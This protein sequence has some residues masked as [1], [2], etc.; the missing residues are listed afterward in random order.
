MKKLRTYLNLP[1]TPS[2]SSSSPKSKPSI[3]DPMTYGPG[4]ATITTVTGPEWFS[5][6][7]LVAGH[8]NPAN[9]V[10]PVGLGQRLLR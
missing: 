2:S 7:K 10:P 9:E 6:K 4:K 8:I 3:P 5:L 1:L